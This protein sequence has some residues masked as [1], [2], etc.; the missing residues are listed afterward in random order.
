MSLFVFIAGAG[1]AF[2]QSSSSDKFDSKMFPFSIPW[3]DASKTVI[4]C[5]SLN[6][7]PAGVSGYVQAK[8]GQFIDAKG[9]RKRLFGVNFGA[10][11]A[12]PT[13][14]DA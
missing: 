13:H 2:A 14:S 10:D 4:D 1:S 9:N 7:T 8:G 5:S 3:D 6:P 11:A 12:F